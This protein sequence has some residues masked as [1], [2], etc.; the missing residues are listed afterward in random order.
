MATS[1]DTAGPSTPEQETLRLFDA[2]ASAYPALGRYS[3]VLL[4]RVSLI[5]YP[6]L[7]LWSFWKVVGSNSQSHLSGEMLLP[8]GPCPKPQKAST[9][10]S[11]GSSQR[12]DW[13]GDLDV[14]VRLLDSPQPPQG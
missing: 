2:F 10:R 1:K 14:D 8:L 4:E 5:P 12:V 6:Q 3:L 13:N 11:K 7:P 9:R